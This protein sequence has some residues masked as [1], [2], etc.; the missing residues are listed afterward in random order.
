MKINKDIALF[1]FDKLAEALSELPVMITIRDRQSDRYVFVNRDRLLT[2]IL[3]EDWNKLDKKQKRKYFDPIERKINM[4]KYHEWV[5]SEK[6]KHL[7]LMYQFLIEESDSRWIRCHFYKDI[8]E[9]EQYIIEISWD[10]TKI[11][12]QLENSDDILAQLYKQMKYERNL[13]NAQ[14]MVIRDAIESLID[15]QRLKEFIQR[16]QGEHQTDLIKIFL[17]VFPKLADALNS[18]IAKKSLDVLNRY[19]DLEQSAQWIYNELCPI[20]L[21]HLKELQSTVGTDLVMLKRSKKL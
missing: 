18:N 9:T 8:G 2:D 4:A 20:L 14:S 15:S 17:E 10:I 5:V 13:A 11:V 19:E 6:E 7:D 3:I 12:S 21:D 16:A 1:T